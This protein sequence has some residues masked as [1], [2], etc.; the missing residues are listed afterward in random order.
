[1]NDI[2]IRIKKLPAVMQEFTQACLIGYYEHSVTQDHSPMT[3]TAATEAIYGTSG[4]GSRRAVDQLDFL[5]D[6]GL[7]KSQSRGRF[8]WYSLPDP[9]VVDEWINADPQR[10]QYAAE[11][12]SY[13]TFTF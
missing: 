1:M 9:K 6:R 11:T 2:E 10:K 13:L 12:R 3:K 8:K 7:L 4:R 5:V